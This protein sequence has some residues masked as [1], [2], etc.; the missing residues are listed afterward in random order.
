MRAGHQHPLSFFAGIGG[1]SNAG[2]LVKGSNYL[3][4]LSQTKYVVF[5]KTGTLTQGVFE[6]NAV[7]H[8]KMKEERLLE[9]AALAESAS[10]HPQFS[11]SLQRAYGKEIDRSRVTDIKEISGN[12]VMAKVD[13]ISVAAG[14]AKLMKRLGV[15]WIDCHHAG[16]IIHMAIDGEYAGHI[17]I[18]DIG[19]PGAK[20]AVRALRKA[21]WR[22]PVC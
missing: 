11:R 20:E 13:G 7:H 19:E 10:S 1:A 3:E 21:G 9:Y 5:D 17:V 4:I 16:T 8:N 14:N 2:V 22:R 18:Y 15:Q 6:V 12:G